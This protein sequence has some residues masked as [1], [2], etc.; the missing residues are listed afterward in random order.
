MKK[1]KYGLFLLL[2]LVLVI[3]TLVV[4]AADVTIDTFDNVPQSITGNNGTPNPFNSTADASALGGER[5]FQVNWLLGADI[6]LASN[7]GVPPSGLLTFSSATGS[8]GRGTVTFD[9]NDNDPALATQG[10]CTPN[11]VDLTD[12]GSNAYLR[13]RI[14]ENDLA[15]TLHFRLY[16]GITGNINDYIEYALPLPGSIAPDSNVDFLMP[17]S[18]FT[19]HGAGANPNNVG[20]IQVFF[21]RDTAIAALDVAIDFFDATGK[22]HDF[23]DLPNSYGTLLVDNGPRHRL[24]TG[25]RLGTSRDAETDGKPSTNASDDHYD[26]GVVRDTDFNWDTNNGGAVYVHIAGCAGSGPA[27][28]CRLNGW[29][30]WNNNGTFET[31]ERVINNTLVSN[32]DAQYF[33][34]P[35]PSGQGFPGHPQIAARF[36]VCQTSPANQ[37]D[38]PTGESQTGEV[39]DYIW[40]FGPTAVSLQS[41]TGAS[42]SAVLPLLM[43]VLLLSVVGVGALLYRR[44]LR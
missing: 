26:D 13:V 7:S 4:Y 16:N 42:N 19:S 10:L 33:P 37:C 27:N 14:A 38:S 28:G 23:G 22:S 40:G 1:L 31:S 11:C 43:I 41:F 6:T 5:D 24:T 12:S 3:G 34:F 18:A 15:A 20:A 32:G 21:N 8:S 39:E 35:I 2:T 44:Q 9:G 17:F 36:R 25:L 30:D 29:I